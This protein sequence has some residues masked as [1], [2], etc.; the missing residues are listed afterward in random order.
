[1]ITVHSC[2]IC[3]KVV[4]RE[5]RFGKRKGVLLPVLG[6]KVSHNGLVTEIKCCRCGKGIITTD[7]KIVKE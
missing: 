3:H 2:P 7:K 6:A 5:D 1:M 4:A